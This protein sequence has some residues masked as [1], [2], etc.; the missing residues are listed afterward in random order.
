MPLNT[1]TNNNIDVPVTPGKQVRNLKKELDKK[2]TEND[3]LRAQVSDL[4]KAIDTLSI[5]KGK[6]DAD[7]ATVMTTA[8]TSTTTKKKKDKDA[9]VPPKTAYKYYCDYNTKGDAVGDLR[10]EWK[11]C[12]PDIRQQFVNMAAADKARY[13]QQMA[14]YEEEKAALEMYY[15]KKKQDMAME[16]YEAHL[17]AQSALEQSSV[18]V[19]GK[20]KKKKTKDPEAPKR[21]LS[22]Y[23]F[24]V[25]DQRESV[26]IANPEASVTDI[27]KILGE[28]WNKLEKG[29]GGKNGTKKYDD[30]AA[31][32][33]VRYEGE[34]AEYEAMVAKRNAEAEQAKAEQLITDKEEALKLFRSTR[35]QVTT[36]NRITGAAGDVITADTE[37]MSV[38]SDMTSL[39]GG[40]KPKKKKDPN[41]PKRA[42]SAYIYF[43]TNN[44]ESIKSSM[45]EGTTQGELM[46]EMGRQWKEL[47]DKK[48][49]KYVKMASKDKI[50]YEKEMKKYNGEQ[51][52]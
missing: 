5:V 21:S 29:K 47:T 52:K 51:K 6:V 15:Q 11:E 24:F 41:A 4:T 46:S 44:R 8:S 1:L 25:S 26:K 2:D 42:L 27:T 30:L 32:D 7:A 28:E 19:D 12:A 38:V 22:A 13:Q 36:V 9:P 18:G 3:D 33:K 10:K 20:L 37:D 17:A 48:K 45:K 40:K 34:K 50:R 14:A 39:P 35:Q 49:E 23:M 31:A 43:C 16:F